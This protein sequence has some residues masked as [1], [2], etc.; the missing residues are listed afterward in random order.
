LGALLFYG[1]QIY[2][3][4]EQIVTIMVDVKPRNGL[5]KRSDIIPLPLE[6]TLSFV[7]LIVNN[8]GKV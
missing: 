7:N 5:L 1:K 3:L 4:H 2:I 8:H 6:Y